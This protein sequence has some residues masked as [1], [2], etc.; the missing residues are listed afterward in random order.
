MYVAGYG[1]AG[2][3]VPGPL[4]EAILRIVAETYEM[5]EET[6][7][8]TTIARVPYGVTEQLAEYVLAESM[9]CLSS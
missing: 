2:S 6:I 7:S 8:G 1:T 3:S 4:R 5:R 9:L